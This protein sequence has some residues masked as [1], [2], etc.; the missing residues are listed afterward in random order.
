MIATVNGQAHEL[1]E[2]GVTIGEL[3]ALL[4]TARAGI[5]VAC[6]DSVVGR[7]LYDRHRVGEGDRIEIIKAAAGG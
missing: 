6:N 3:L 2:E 7:D 5:A 1:P 4:G